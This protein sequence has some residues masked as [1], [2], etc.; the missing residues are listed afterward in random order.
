MASIAVP[1]DQYKP[2]P[3]AQLHDPQALV[4]QRPPPIRFKCMYLAVLIV[5]LIESIIAGIVIVV[6]I[7]SSVG[8]QRVVSPSES[9]QLGS[10]EITLSEE[11]AAPE[12]V[13]LVPVFLVLALVIVIL[14]QYLGWRGYTNHNICAIYTFAFTKGFR[15]LTSLFLLFGTGE[16]T[17]LVT[18]ILYIF[19]TAFPILFAVEVAKHAH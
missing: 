5:D 10:A 6:A 8:L 15:A 12:D 4:L 17:F 9:V 19:F 14:I 2:P 1:M 7:F 16:P 18:F 3:Y 11:S 13:W